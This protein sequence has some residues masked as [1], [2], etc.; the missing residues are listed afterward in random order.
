MTRLI[1]LLLLRN[2]GRVRTIFS[3]KNCFA[4]IWE[5]FQARERKVDGYIET[6]SDESFFFSRCVRAAP[7]R[8]AIYIL[9]ATAASK[10]KW[11]LSFGGT[12]QSTAAD[13]TDI[14]TMNIVLLF[15]CH[16]LKLSITGE[17][18]IYFWDQRCCFQPAGIPWLKFCV[19]CVICFLFVI[20]IANPSLSTKKGVFAFFRV[21][22]ATHNTNM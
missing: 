21:C 4:N 11:I 2:H 13:Y 10:V 8:R 7:S 9:A 16:K 5:G 6:A 15:D 14:L 1:S 22:F 17:G 19:R 12:E 3:I 20:S 18:C